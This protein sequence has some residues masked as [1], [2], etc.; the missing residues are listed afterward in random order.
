M[1][2]SNQHSFWELDFESSASTNSANG[3]R[4]KRYQRL[5]IYTIVFAPVNR[6]IAIF[7]TAITKACGQGPVTAIYSGT[8][9]T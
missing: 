7:A 9:P 8:E 1:P 6:E 5:G 2:G 4:L 3:A